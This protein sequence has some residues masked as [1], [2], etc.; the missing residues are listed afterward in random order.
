MPC[1][2]PDI[3]VPE[4]PSARDSQSHPRRNVGVI[5]RSYQMDAEMDVAHGSDG[6]GR[7]SSRPE[8]AEGAGGA[9][10]DEDGGR[11]PEQHVSVAETQLSAVRVRYAHQLLNR[12]RGAG[13]RMRVRQ[14]QPGCPSPNHPI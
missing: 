5:P 10:F 12:R 8:L 14:L 7:T 2:F 9:V 4:P 11:S 1:D 3:H 6:N 13:P